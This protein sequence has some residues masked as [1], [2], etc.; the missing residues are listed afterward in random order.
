MESNH[1]FPAC[2]AGVFAVGP[3]DRNVSDRGGSRTHTVAGSRPARFASLRT[4]S[5]FSSG[6]GGRSGQAERMKLCWVL[7][8]PRHQVTKG[9]LE[10]P[11][12]GARLSESRVSACSTTWLCESAT[13]AGIE[14][15][16]P[17]WKPGTS[18]AR[19][20]AQSCGG[21]NRTCVGVINSHLPV[22]A[23]VPP[24]NQSQDGW[25]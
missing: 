22:P 15:A 14:P 20:R 10:L 19:P 8:H 3:R 1:H 2:Q 25:I 18:A 9:R 16:S 21:R 17:G 11:C 12:L 7:A 24:Q 4:R 23:R 6:S 13:R 5:Y